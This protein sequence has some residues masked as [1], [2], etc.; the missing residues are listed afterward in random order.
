MN[1]ESSDIDTYDHIDLI[2]QENSEMRME[3]VF[4]NERIEEQFEYPQENPKQNNDE[5]IN[6]TFTKISDINQIENIDKKC[7]KYKMHSIEVK[8]KCLELVNILKIC[9][10]R[11]PIFKI[12]RHSIC[13]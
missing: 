5:I 12:I 4:L 10:I 11:L 7:K 2:K 1:K 6:E 13:L 8:R 3:D 9:Q